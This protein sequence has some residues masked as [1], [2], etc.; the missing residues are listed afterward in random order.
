MNTVVG[1][2]E[3]LWIAQW[4]RMNSKNMN[5]TICSGTLTFWNV[6]FWHSRT[7]VKGTVLLKYGSSGKLVLFLSCVMNCSVTLGKSP[8]VFPASVSLPQHN[9]AGSAFLIKAIAWHWVNKRKVVWD[10]SAC[11]YLCSGISQ[12]KNQQQQKAIVIINFAELLQ[13]KDGQAVCGSD[14]LA[15]QHRDASRCQEGKQ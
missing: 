7:V 1:G 9:R 6:K 11:S 3:D 10:L 8:T 4:W 5:C 15:C 14:S 2:Q 13:M 12:Q